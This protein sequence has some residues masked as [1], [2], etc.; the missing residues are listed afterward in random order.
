MIP[1]NGISMAAR[2]AAI[3]FLLCSFASVPGAQETRSEDTGWQLSAAI[4]DQE[5]LLS[6]SIEGKLILEDL[7]RKGN[8]LRAENEALQAELETEER[9]LT[10]MR[11]TAGADQAEFRTLANAFDSKVNSIRTVQKQKL[12][13]LNVEY[14]QER[15]RFFKKAE[16]V[17]L[18]MMQERGIG[19]IVGRQAIL[20][21]TSAAD[22]TDDVIE[23]MDLV[24]QSDREKQ[25]GE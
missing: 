14:E 1:N 23:R 15:E 4:V 11:K 25:D 6:D 5:R 3:V 2:S 17:M 7:N 22:I 10:E 20:L 9:T 21:A 12:E 24:Y 8:E 16:Q 18:E 13:R 19:M